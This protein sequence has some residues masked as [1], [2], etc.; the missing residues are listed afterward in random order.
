MTLNGYFAFNSVFAPVCLAS[1]RTTFENN[2][3]KTD[4]DRYILLAVEVLSRD[5]TGYMISRGFSIKEASKDWG[6]ALTLV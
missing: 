6:R 2:C 5:S 1:D 3:V 4:K